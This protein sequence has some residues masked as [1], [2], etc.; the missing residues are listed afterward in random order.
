LEVSRK[1]G[2]IY[3]ASVN[4]IIYSWSVEKI[5]SKEFFNSSMKH[6]DCFKLALHV[7]PMYYN[8]NLSPLKLHL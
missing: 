1:K 6:P 4:G 7:N 5:F 8:K 2:I 3:G